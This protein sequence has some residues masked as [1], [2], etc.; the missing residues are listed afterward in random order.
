MRKTCML[1]S[2]LTLA[3][4]VGCVEPGGVDVSQLINRYQRM[5]AQRPAD[6]LRESTDGMGIY[7]PD[8]ETTIPRL[9]V[10]PRRDPNTGQEWTEVRLP[11]QEA[12]IRA[13]MNNS[14]IHVTGYDPAVAR[15]EI[16]KAAAAFDPVVTGGLSWEW[17][18]R[19]NST[20]GRTRSLEPQVG[21]NQRTPTGA[22][23]GL[24]AAFPQTWDE[25][26][27]REYEPELVAE[28]TQPLLRNGWKRFNLAELRLARV[29][30]Q[31]NLETFRQT[32]EDVINRVIEAYWTLYQ[33]RINLAIQEAL[34]EETIRINNIIQ[35]HPE[36][37]E[38]VEKKQT[39]STEINRRVTLIELRKAVADAQEQLARLLQDPQ[40]N[41]RG[42][43]MIIPVTPPDD[44]MI[45]YD[46][47]DQLLLAL[48]HSPALR[49]ARLAI[50]AAAIQ[51]EIAQNQALPRLDFIASA[52]YHG[53]DSELHQSLEEWARFE[54]LS[55][56]LGLEVEYPLG[57][58][59][60]L[61]ELYSRQLQRTQAMVRMQET[62]DQL[63]Q[64]IQERIRQVASAYARWQKRNEEVAILRDLV[65]GFRTLTLQKATTPNNLQ[66]LLDAQ[67][68]LAQ[69]RSQQVSALVEY[70]VAQKD[71]AQITGTILSLENLRV[72]LPVAAD[73]APWPASAVLEEAPDDATP[74]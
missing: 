41:L 62:S 61:A 16:V 17:T 72:A 25:I 39:Q 35:V 58:R 37:R 45:E 71:L 60:R 38:N 69:A 54:H 1:C 57:N 44:A 70:N 59:A 21:I 53:S 48:K 46:A 42:E 22:T 63:A 29:S 24:R 23:V 49:Q 50:R 64:S 2:A 51:V 8:D 65:D 13:L 28:L 56:S 36:A 11:L 40:I 20:F 7:R 18:N 33:A 52:G 32:V 66:L 14:E 3:A 68:R 12:V 43:L 19:Q 55:D 73:E 67:G 34:L 47:A 5:V 74:E 4:L 31:A 6:A 27:R 15:Q 26:N 30:H 9:R 10:I